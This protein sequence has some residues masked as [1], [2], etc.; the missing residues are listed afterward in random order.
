MSPRSAYF[1]NSYGHTRR[2]EAEATASV[3]LRADTDSPLTIA[4]KRDLFTTRCIGRCSEPLSQ[5]AGKHIRGATA[6]DV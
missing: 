5:V 4:Q 3:P 1:H 6:C 2:I